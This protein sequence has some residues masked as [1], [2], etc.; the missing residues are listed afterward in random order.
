MSFS[1]D[2]VRDGTLIAIGAGAA[3]GLEHGFG[4]LKTWAKA[5]ATRVKSQAESVY[6]EISS[7]V[8]A[9][10]KGKTDQISQDVAAAAALA[11]SLAGRVT[12]LEGGKADAA[13]LNSLI[14]KLNAKN[15]I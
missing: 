13:A 7:A 2:A 8:D 1:F 15:L 3:L 11:T 5:R 4:W 12:A 6:T 9:A 10:L 14:A